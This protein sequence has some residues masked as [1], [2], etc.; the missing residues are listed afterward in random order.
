MQVGPKNQ[1]V[2]KPARKVGEKSGLR[3]SYRERS[4]CRTSGDEQGGGFRQRR[5]MRGCPIDGDYAGGDDCFQIMLRA[6]RIV[7]VDN[8]GWCTG[9][10]DSAVRFFSTNVTWL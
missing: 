5:R 3:A 10:D 7:D 9:G 1:G 2:N 4:T 6:E 8:H